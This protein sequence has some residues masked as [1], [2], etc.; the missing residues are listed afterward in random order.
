MDAKV[1]VYESGMDDDSSGV[2][3]EELNYCRSLQLK[4]LPRVFV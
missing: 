3:R 1:W 4:K 2:I